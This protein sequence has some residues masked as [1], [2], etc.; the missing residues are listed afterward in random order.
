MCS[1]CKNIQNIIYLYTDIL[2]ILYNIKIWLFDIF[3]ENLKDVD[4]T[5][6]L[7]LLIEYSSNIENYSLKEANGLRSIYC[8]AKV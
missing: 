1:K 4:N 2:F 5:Q 7:N 8:V 3:Y 6:V